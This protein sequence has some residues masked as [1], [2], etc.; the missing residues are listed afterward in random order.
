MGGLPARHL[1]DCGNLERL[2]GEVQNYWA[3]QTLV[4]SASHFV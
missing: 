3:S 2:W 4:V 1:L